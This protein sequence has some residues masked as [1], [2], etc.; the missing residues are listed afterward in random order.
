VAEEQTYSWRAITDHAKVVASDGKE[1][2]FVVEV[3][4]LPNEDIFHGVVFRSHAFGHTHL[5]PADDVG[6]I[7]PDTVHL[8]VDSEAAAQYPQFH[9]MDV[10]RLSLKGLFRWKHPGWKKS[11]E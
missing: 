8:S 1:V 2:G 11:S 3:A 6:T 9:E 10:E 4:A 5:A 7:T